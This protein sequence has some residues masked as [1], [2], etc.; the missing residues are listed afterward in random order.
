ML[1]EWRGLIVSCFGPWI[2]ARAT[3]RKLM[4]TVINKETFNGKL[5]SGHE[6][7][8]NPDLESKTHLPRCPKYFLF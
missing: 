8:V 2:A 1:S 5:P 6:K 7:Y 4:G 3:G